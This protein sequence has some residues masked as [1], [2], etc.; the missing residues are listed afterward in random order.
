MI[1]VKIKDFIF[2]F[3]LL[4]GKNV[5]ITGSGRG[6]GKEVAKACAKEGANI[7]LTSRTIEELELVKQEINDLGTDVKVVIKTADIT[8]FTDVETAFKFFNDELGPLNGVIANAGM[9]RM[10]PS[11]E[12]DSDKFSTIISINILGVFNTFK[13]AYPF[14]K[15][16]DK[17]SKARFIIT[18]SAI[19]PNVM[20]QFAAYSASKFGVVGL[21]KELALEYK[22][23]NITFNSM[24]PTMVDTR[25]LRGRKAGDGNKPDNVMNPWDLND[26]YVFLLSDGANR[27]NNELITTAEL[28]DIK[29][30][31]KEVSTDK[32]QNWEDIKEIL[33]EKAPKIV[34]KVKKWSKLIEFILNR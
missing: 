5:V 13:G 18:G 22:S 3:M 2:F 6:I 32:K 10:G 30:I 17:K 28:Q 31:F 19:Y 1:N 4:K 11:H 25:M 21:Q 24:L 26:Y 12:F 15:K 29:Q 20:P 9:S 16:D 23:E 33:E 8:N 14:L 34:D 27:I 7:G